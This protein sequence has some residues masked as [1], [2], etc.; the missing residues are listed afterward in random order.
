VQAEQ[1]DFLASFLLAISPRSLMD[2]KLQKGNAQE[3]QKRFGIKNALWIA[4]VLSYT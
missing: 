4:F 1:Q 3:A 2:G